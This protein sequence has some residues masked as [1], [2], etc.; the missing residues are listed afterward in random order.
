MLYLVSDYKNPYFNIALEEYLFSSDNFDDD[1]IIVWRNEKS[2]FLGKNQN[3][4]VEIAHSLINDRKIPLLRRISGGGTVYHDLG[5]VNMTFI[6]KNVKLDKIDFIKYTKFMQE[7]LGYF[8]V[9]ATYS[10]RKDLLVDGKKVSGS[11][12]CIRGNK[13]LYHGTLLFSSNL[14]NLSEYLNTNKKATSNATKSVRSKVTNLNE[15]IDM[16]VE[17]FMDKIKEYI[18]LNVEAPNE[19][20]LNDVDL[21]QIN[22]NTEQIYSKDKWIF[23]KTPKFDTCIDGEDNS[24]V[25]ISVNKWRVKSFI[26]KYKNSD[27]QVMLNKLIGELFFEKNIMEIANEKYRQY[28]DIIKA[29]F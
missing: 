12:Q 10:D 21:E 24:V 20:I 27:K 6:Q 4:Y 22:Q 16:D 3:P 15:Y 5:N 18:V 8:G 23:E 25:E 29:V 14:N 11:A 26:I 2:I 1:I 28:I 7:M 9:K 17:E 13:C 19:I